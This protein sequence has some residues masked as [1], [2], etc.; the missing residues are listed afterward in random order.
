VNL[1][2]QFFF[3]SESI[4][5]PAVFS[6]FFAYIPSYLAENVVILEGQVLRREQGV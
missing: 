1:P 2:T 6:P 4:N 3:L 5:M